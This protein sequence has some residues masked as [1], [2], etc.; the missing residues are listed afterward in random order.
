MKFTQILFNEQF[1]DDEEEDT[2]GKWDLNSPNC[3]DIC[4]KANALAEFLDVEPEEIDEDSYGYYDM[5]QFKTGDVTYAVGNEDETQ[6]SAV[7]Y[8][9]NLIDDVGYDGFSKS[10]VWQH[11][12]EDKVLE[13]IR[14]D[15]EWRIHDS[16][17]SYLDDEDRMLS[18]RQLK[19]IEYY[20]ERIEFY[21][22]NIERFEELKDT[23]E[24]EDEIDNVD[25]KIEEL[26]EYIEDAEREIEDIESDPDG[27]WSQYAID[28]YIDN[29]MYD[30]EKNI[31]YHMS[32]YGFELKE[33]IDR[34]AFIKAVIDEDG[35]GMMNSYDGTYDEIKFNGE[36]FYIIR[37]D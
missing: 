23:L 27:D 3:Y 21:K 4:I 12:D 7:E 11:I 34:D 37:V 15:V 5:T 1:P 30:V 35:Y 16:P 22:K 18:A 24:D 19:Q 36:T 26:E 31:E 20:K 9:D 33:F 25:T 8:V 29:F 17:D 13:A 6:K 10:F 14:E 32:E 2:E 28:N